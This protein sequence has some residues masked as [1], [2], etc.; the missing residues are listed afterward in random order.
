[1]A[2]QAVFQ[3]VWMPLL[4]WQAGRF[5]NRLEDPKV[6]RA[7]QT[8]ALLRS[9]QIFRAIGR[10]N[11]QPGAQCGYFIKKWISQAGASLPFA[12]LPCQNPRTQRAGVALPPRCGG[13]PYAFLRRQDALRSGVLAAR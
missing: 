3:H 4:G 5:G 6:L 13:L 11:L 8:A 1:M 7:V 2:R 12:C 9:E 10:P